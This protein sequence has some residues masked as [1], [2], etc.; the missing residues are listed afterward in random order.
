MGHDVDI[1]FNLQVN[2]FSSAKYRTIFNI[3]QGLQCG[4]V[5]VALSHWCDAGRLSF[6]QV[7]RLI[8]H[9]LRRSAHYKSALGHVLQNFQFHGNVDNSALVSYQLYGIHVV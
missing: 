2:L 4:V 8:C 5:V 3:A 1:F 6:C 7:C 9:Y